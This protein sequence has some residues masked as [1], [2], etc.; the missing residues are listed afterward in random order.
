M[1]SNILDSA[2]LT[3]E[4]KRVYNQMIQSTIK[5]LQIG[6]G[7]FL[8]GFFDWM[9][10]ES[11]KQGL[12]DGSVVVVQPRPSGKAKIEALASQDGVYT[13]VTRGLE[14]NVPIE[15]MDQITVFGTVFDPYEHW[16]EF[17]ALAELPELRIVVSNTTEAG[18]SY[19]PE[20]WKEGEPIN[21]Y[22]GKLTML[23]YHRYKAFQG[24]PE[25]G[26]ICL[27]CELLERNGDTLR[28][29]ILRYCEDWELPADFRNWVVTHN[30]FLNSLVDRIVTGYPKQDQ[31]EAWF[32]EWGYRDPM[33]TTAEP[34]HLWAIEGDPSLDQELPLASAGLNVLW[35]EDLK[36]YQVRKVS[37]LNGAHTFMALY[38]TLHG[39]KEV[40]LAMEDSHIGDL[41]KRTIQNEIIPS[42]PYNSVELQQ[43][44][45]QVYQRFLNPFIQHRLSDI[46]M[47]SLSKFKTR[48]L[49]AIQYYLADEQFTELPKGL[50]TASAALIRYYQISKGE[51][52]YEGKSF[53]GESYILHDDPILLEQIANIW[54][55]YYSGENGSSSINQVVSQILQ[56]EA[57]WGV[58]M[59]V[60]NANLATQLSAILI[61]WEGYGNE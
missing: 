20:Q 25:R 15:R 34:Y 56:I 32:N 55:N 13:L 5:V 37:I 29:C 50:A 43:Y 57:I 3:T 2:S 1:K 26:F 45:V 4:K 30:L 21:S 44:A 58:N 11:R 23:L 7:N 27:P 19:H 46:A 16:N 12:Y 24:D 59:H 54:E 40:R 47:N 51:A 18:L 17:L 6:E 9:I 8:R 41:I 35:V 33:L 53:D 14:N 10:Y 39:I 36:P 38:G 60:S 48:L 49:P 61:Q 42:L 22:P 52:G 28:D 31:A